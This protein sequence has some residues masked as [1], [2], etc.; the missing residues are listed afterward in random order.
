MVAVTGFG[1]HQAVTN[2]LETAVRRLCLAF[3]EAEEFR[4]HGSANFRVPGGK[5]F[6]TYVVNHHGDGRIALWLPAPTGLQEMYVTQEPRHF[7]V[8]PYVGPRGWLGVRLDRR[9][10]WKRICQLARNAY[11]HVA[12]PRL[13]T[14]IGRTPSVPA[15]GL[16]ITAADLDPSTTPRGKRIMACLRKICLALPE[17]H[18]GAQFGH[19][20]WR[21]GKRVFAQA[22]CREHR[23]RVA[24]W[25]GVPAQA[26]ML[27]DARFEIPPYMGHNGWMSLDVSK[28]H[29]ENELRAL[30]LNSYRHFAL[31]RMLARCDGSITS[32]HGQA[33][34]PSGTREV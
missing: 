25:V 3:P 7:F 18:E 24:F 2:E 16:R 9:L 8:P 17:T 20:V 30:L 4:S 22:C 19:S 33:R 34:L 32:A 11:E 28:S 15:P 29:R 21:A 6:A 31:K 10:P 26:L 1:H 13:S 5:T 14:S 23:W 27:S 12:P